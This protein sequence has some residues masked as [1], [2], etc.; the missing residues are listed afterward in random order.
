MARLCGISRAAVTT[1]ARLATSRHGQ[2]EFDRVT[3]EKEYRASLQLA[4]FMTSHGGLQD[5]KLTVGKWPAKGAPPALLA[6]SALLLFRTDYDARAAARLF[7]RLTQGPAAADPRRANIIGLNPF[8]DFSA[9]RAVKL[10]SELSEEA[11]WSF[12]HYRD[13]QA[14][15]ARLRRL[16]TEWRATID[17]SNIQ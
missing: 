8:H 15:E 14:A 5:G 17:A 1:A 9:W 13:F 2:E 4:E 10:A 16:H 7:V 6:L 11:G 3:L 12:D